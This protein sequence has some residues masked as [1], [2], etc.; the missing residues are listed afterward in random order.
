MLPVAVETQLHRPKPLGADRHQVPAG[1]L[2]DEDLAVTCV[3]VE[4]TCFDCEDNDHSFPIE[5]RSEAFTF[6]KAL[7]MQCLWAPAANLDSE[8]GVVEGGGPERW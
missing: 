1:V 4:F 2:E 5:S 8:A 3:R 7:F 6:L